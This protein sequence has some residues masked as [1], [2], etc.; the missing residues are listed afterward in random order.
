MTK[1]TVLQELFNLE[2]NLKEIIHGLRQIDGTWSK[3]FD[4]ADPDDMYLCTTFAKVEDEL[5]AVRRMIQG[6]G[7]RVVAQGMLIKNGDGQYVIENADAVLTAGSV[8]EVLFRSSE[9]DAEWI[10]SGVELCGG[11][12]VLTGFPRLDLEGLTVRIKQ[13]PSE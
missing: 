3:H 9:Q 8:V 11:E 2:S 7:A 12:Y 1:D 6:I 4:P 10:E 5:S 13:Y